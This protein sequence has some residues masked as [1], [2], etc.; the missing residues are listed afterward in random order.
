M[1]IEIQAGKDAVL[2][3]ADHIQYLELEL[4]GNGHAVL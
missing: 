3:G 2:G 1:R 4:R